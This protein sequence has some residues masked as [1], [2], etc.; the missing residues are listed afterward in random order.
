[1]GW[2]LILGGARPY[3]T[4][5]R[6]RDHCRVL[7]ALEAKWFG[8][9]VQATVFEPFYPGSKRDGLASL[10]F[11]TYVLSNKGERQ[12]KSSEAA[13]SLPARGR[14]NGSR[15]RYVLIRYSAHP[16]RPVLLAPSSPSSRARARHGTPI[17]SA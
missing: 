8:L 15:G 2:D 14:R 17:R 10:P 9:S 6:F 12:W 5:L 7:A 4:S 1:M 13:R 11:D 16:I 3:A